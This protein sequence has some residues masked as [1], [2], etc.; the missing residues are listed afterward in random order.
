MECFRRHVLAVVWR[1]FP[2]P[3][4]GGGHRRAR[5]I[6]AQCATSQCRRSRRPT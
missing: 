4:I 5:S 2:C 6:F 3:E 1:H